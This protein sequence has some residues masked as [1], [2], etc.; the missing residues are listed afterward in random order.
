MAC[1]H[2]QCLNRCKC[3][4]EAELALNTNYEEKETPWVNCYILYIGLLEVDIS[5]YI[6]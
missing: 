6:C 5:I 1:V 2:K 3:I 4:S